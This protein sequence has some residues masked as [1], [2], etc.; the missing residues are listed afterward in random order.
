MWYD[1]C[2]YMSTGKIKQILLV[3]YSFSSVWVYLYYPAR[4]KMLRIL[5]QTYATSVAFSLRG[6][7]LTLSFS[8]KDFVEYKFVASW[9]CRARTQQSEARTNQ[10]IFKGGKDISFLSLETEVVSSSLL[11]RFPR[12]SWVG[13]SRQQDSEQRMKNTLV[14]S[15][16]DW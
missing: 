7:C 9:L 13:P 10:W 1:L 12:I 8:S 5:L 16:G 6:K 11:T 3:Q 2:V 15:K 14:R 4:W